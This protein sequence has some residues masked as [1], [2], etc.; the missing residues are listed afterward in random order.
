MR[1]IERAR[2][3]KSVQEQIHQMQEKIRR[4]EQEGALKDTIAREHQAKMQS[5]YQRVQQFDQNCPLCMEHLT[6]DKLTELPCGHMVH[7]RCLSEMAAG[8]QSAM[9]TLWKDA[10]YLNY[11]SFTSCP[12]CR[13][14]LTDFSVLSQLPMVVSQSMTDFLSFAKRAVRNSGV[15]EQDERQQ[16]AALSACALVGK[17]RLRATE[18]H[19]VV[20]GMCKR[21][22]TDG[23]LRFTACNACRKAFVTMHGGGCGANDDE[24]TPIFHCKPCLDKERRQNSHD[25]PW[26]HVPYSAHL[27]GTMHLCDNCEAPVLRDP[28]SRGACSHQTCPN[29]NY[30]FCYVCGGKYSGFLNTSHA[31]T[32]V[33][34][35]PFCAKPDPS[36]RN[37]AGHSFRFGRCKCTERIGRER[38][39]RLSRGVDVLPRGLS[40]ATSSEVSG[41]GHVK[42]AHPFA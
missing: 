22:L 12:V 1:R 15:E 18:E 16:S 27:E 6:A 29:C 23:D 9:K 37:R 36:R 42:L 26:S 11:G 31:L 30:Q 28:G 39:A 38:E 17:T 40:L 35:I 33:S 20:A 4:Q 19:R 5:K 10:G 34:T 21:M 41:Y 3:E 13:T 7:M 24:V 14:N 32:S 8:L 2:A 25:L